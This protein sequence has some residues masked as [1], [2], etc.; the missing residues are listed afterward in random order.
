MEL[1]SLKTA[2]TNEFE[3]PQYKILLTSYLLTRQNPNIQEAH[4]WEKR[5]RTHATFLN[6]LDLDISII[7]ESEFKTLEQLFRIRGFDEDHTKYDLWKQV[8]SNQKE[9]NKFRNHAGASPIV[10]PSK[11][12]LFIKPEPL[13]FFPDLKVNPD[14][15]EVFTPVKLRILDESTAQSPSPEAS[16]NRETPTH[17]S[18]ASFNP[19]EKESQSSNKLLTVKRELIFITPNLEDNAAS[20]LSLEQRPHQYTNILYQQLIKNLE[21]EFSSSQITRWA[22]Y[23]GSNGAR[24]LKTMRKP[25]YGDKQMRWNNL[26]ESLKKQG[27]DLS[28]YL[29]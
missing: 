19:S 14:K 5:T 2:A 1:Y 18:P 11:E 17:S 6:T 26:L 21:K 3:T 13:V 8:Y 4:V 27:K 16:S 15:Q 23:S 20:L 10:K 7:T 28:A 24:D 25:Q 22:G 9:S 12:L 29:G